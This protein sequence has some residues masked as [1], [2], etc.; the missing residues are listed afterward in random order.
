M[1]VK[2]KHQLIRNRLYLI[3]YYINPILKA[4]LVN[5]ILN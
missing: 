1:K 4:F 5:I 2:T 3:W